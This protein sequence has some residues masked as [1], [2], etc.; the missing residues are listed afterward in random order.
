LKGLFG[1]GNSPVADDSQVPE[2]VPPREP[3]QE[4]SSSSAP[5]PSQAAESTN[6]PKEVLKDLSTI[7]LN[8]TIKFGSLPPMTAV[9]KRAAR[10]RYAT[11][12]F[13]T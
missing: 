7:A 6:L 13:D 4:P 2:S 8:V 12:F 1:G 9:D 3:D 5:S 11:F 10:S